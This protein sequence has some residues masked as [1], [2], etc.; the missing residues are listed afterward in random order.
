M[1]IMFRF[2]NVMDP[3]KLRISFSR[4]LEI[5][6][7]KNLG[8]RLRMNVLGQHHHQWIFTE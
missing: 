7:W 6:D 8:A 1:D 2:D 3:E 5:G 4:L